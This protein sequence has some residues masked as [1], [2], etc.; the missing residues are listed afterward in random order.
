MELRHLRYFVALAEHLNF[1]H[2]A[3]KVHVTQSMLS[4]QIRQLEDE[5]SCSL[6]ERRGKRV[7]MTEKGEEFL[8]YAQKALREVE[9]GVKAVRAPTA[10]LSGVLRIGTTHTFNMRIIPQCI[11][12]F[13][14]R[15]PSVCVR[16][17][18]MPGHEV[19]DAL[20]SGDL[21]FGVAYKP[22]NA[23][24]LIFEPLYNEELVLVVGPEH[25]FARRRFVHMAELHQLP[26]VLLSPRYAT[27]QLLD[28]CFEMA[29]ARPM[30]VT[31]MNTIAP[32]IELVRR[33]N[34][35]AIVSEHAIPR[36]AALTVRIQ[37]PTPVRTPGLIWRRGEP[38]AA[39]A[40][41]MAAIIR[42]LVASS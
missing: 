10:Q 30:V 41:H 18:E 11:A 6:F 33:A 12:Q 8:Q 28:D 42:A 16:V 5:L 7:A 15:H 2:A 4:H 29:N 17:E 25:L 21:D 22:D 3:E 9:H 38:R 27:R 36:D 40:R 1:T 13:H 19:A 31:E 39:A 14:E 24:P 32:M 34:I 35:A 20:L 37:S 23:S 26:L